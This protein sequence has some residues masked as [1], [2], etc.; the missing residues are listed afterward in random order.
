MGLATK[1]ISD[2]LPATMRTVCEILA[3]APEGVSSS[4]RVE[5]FREIYTFLFEK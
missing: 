4:M 2:G 5:K 3:E 1:S